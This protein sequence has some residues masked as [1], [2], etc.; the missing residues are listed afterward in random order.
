MYGLFHNSVF[1]RRR[2]FAAMKVRKMNPL[3]FPD[4]VDYYERILTKYMEQIETDDIKNFD[5]FASREI[6]TILH[7]F[8][9]ENNIVDQEKIGDIAKNTIILILSL[10]GKGHTGIYQNFDELEESDKGKIRDEL[11]PIICN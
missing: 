9:Q 11:L 3:K 8:K 5:T 4:E 6:A 1:T 2:K 7:E 10:F